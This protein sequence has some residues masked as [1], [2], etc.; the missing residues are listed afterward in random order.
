MELFKKSV[1]IGVSVTPEIGLE[2]AQ[3]D[4]NA[5]MVLKY[6]SRPLEYD[7]NRREIAD[8]DLF[9]ET[10]QDIFLEL[11][12][13]KNAEIVL[14]IPTVIFRVNDY[15]AAL[16]EMEI[17]NA[18]DEELIENPLFNNSEPAVSATLLPNSSIQFNKVAYT[19]AQKS[20]LI[21][22][23]MSIKDLG[24]KILAIDT[25]VNSVLN[26]LIYKDR[27]NVAPETSWVLLEVDNFCCRVMPMI[28]RNYVDAFEEKLSIGAVL[29]DAENYA[30]VVG[31]VAPLLKN[32]PSKYLCVVSKTN[33]ISAEVLASKLQYGAP[34]IHQEANEFS[35]E[36]FLELAP[37]VDPD[38]ANKVS[39]DIIG[40][41]IY[42]DFAQFTS[43][44]FNLYNKT[45]GEIFLMDQPLEISF[46][47]RTIQLSIENLIKF[48]VCIAVPL[49][50]V[51]TGVII[52]L[53]TQIN[54]LKAQN[55]DLE[56]QIASAE[57]FLEDNK[58]VSS[59]MFDEGYEIK[60]GLT[61]NKNIYSYFTIIGTEIPSK[62]WLTHLKL[63][64]KV[65]IEGQA[66]NL[67]SVYAFFRNIKDYNPN[68]DVK[69]QKLGL[70]SSVKSTPQELNDTDADFDTDS[71]LT[72]LNADFYEFKISNEPEINK[73]NLKK[74]EK[75]S[76]DSGLPDLEIIK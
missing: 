2:V 26:A 1:V 59:S 47:G 3:I 24:Y 29:G 53:T 15:P 69:L 60:M 68:S 54:G 30:T 52:F 19:A 16:G 38:V 7:I 13:P 75:K 48:F 23:V 25:S 64:D 49:I 20:M 11:Q 57:K 40:A 36:A 67:E 9:K 41:A 8:L 73:D 22:V 50:L 32:L 74:N 43:A 66:D 35:K 6:A 4:F 31:A 39:L 71:I 5:G 42:R 21:E 58:E 55:A 70:A 65:T 46:A 18:I 56:K 17:T 62:L 14:N 34:I 27:V 28:G 72:S 51:V 10:L 45:L 76:A 61:Q 37:G 33:I 12:I 63:S 44:H